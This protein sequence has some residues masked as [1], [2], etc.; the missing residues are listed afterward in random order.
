MSI[1]AYLPIAGSQAVLLSDTI[2]SN[3]MTTTPHISC[4]Y[5]Y[6][7]KSVSVTKRKLV[8]NTN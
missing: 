5:D 8:E 1:A 3:T 2:N 7:I 4:V 6:S